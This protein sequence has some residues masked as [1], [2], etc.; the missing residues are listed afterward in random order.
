MANWETVSTE[1]QSAY[2]VT[3]KTANSLI[4]E[5]DNYS[6][7]QTVVVK[8]ID[9]PNDPWISI[10][11]RICQLDEVVPETVLIEASETPFG[12]WIDDNFYGLIHSF[13]IADLDENELT[14]PLRLVM[15]H[16]DKMERKLTGRDEL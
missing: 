4:L 16:A 8:H 5:L 7:K 13:P 14:A 2:A 6:R 1:L 10:F 15:E 11:S 12:V 9:S 3:G